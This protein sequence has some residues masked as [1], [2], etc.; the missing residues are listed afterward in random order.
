M[1][2]R[3]LAV[4]VQAGQAVAKGAPLVVLEAMKMEHPMLAPAAA[5]VQRVCVGA[6]AQVAAGTV[7]IELA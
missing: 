4:Q 6:G 2:G 5:T 7:L 1:A 3:I